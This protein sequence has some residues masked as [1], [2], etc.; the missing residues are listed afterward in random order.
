VTWFRTFRASTSPHFAHLNMKGPVRVDP[1]YLPSCILVSNENARWDPRSR[2][3]L[4]SRFYSWTRSRR[5]H[6]QHPRMCCATASPDGDYLCLLGNVH[7]PRRRH[8]IGFSGSALLDGGG[9]VILFLLTPGYGVARWRIRQVRPNLV[10]VYLLIENLT[11][12][13]TK[14]SSA[15]TV[16]YTVYMKNFMRIKCHRLMVH[17]P[18]LSPDCVHPSLREQ[19]ILGAFTSRE[20]IIQSQSCPRLVPLIWVVNLRRRVERRQDYRKGCGARIIR[21]T[22]YF[23]CPLKCH[24]RHLASSLE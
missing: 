5:S 22:R 15:D 9:G 3:Q 18:P 12:A 4:G 6:S 24:R 10:L 2:P 23:E 7:L 16:Q 8:E 13:G 21:H 11:L 19:Q 1:M 17:P 14:N 20:S